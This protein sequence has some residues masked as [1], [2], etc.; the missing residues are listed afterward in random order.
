MFLSLFLLTHTVV[1]AADG[2][3]SPA[4]QSADEVPLIPRKL[5]MGYSEKDRPLISPAGT[6]IAYLAP[7]SEGVMNIWVRTIG[8]SDD[9][10]VT[11]D[12]SNGLFH[13]FWGFND[14]HVLFLQDNQGD[15]N[16]HLKSV[17]LETGKVRDLTPYKDVRAT[18]LLK[19]DQHPEEVMIG[20]NKRD[21]TLFDMY[22]VNLVT[23]A[24]TLEATNP[25]D[26][27][28][29]TTDEKFQIRAATAF[30]DDL[31]TAIRVRDSVDKPW[32]NLL[33][34][35]FERTPFLGQYNG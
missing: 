2:G 12:K 14:Q 1:F 31:S 11:D 3:E 23:G 35:P 28:G 17:D 32:R 33:V 10:M 18:N 7:S 9:R 30:Q 24:V 34:T 22:R 4:L 15:E 20:L 21:K 26:V 5:F 19:D 6:R 13:F 8:K 29:W 25:G 16:A 27:I